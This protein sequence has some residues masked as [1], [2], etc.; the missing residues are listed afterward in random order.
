MVA[1]I[2][3]LI[4]KLAAAWRRADRRSLLTLTAALAATW[5]YFSLDDMDL[6]RSENRV[7][8]VRYA[9]LVQ[10]DKPG[11]QTPKGARLT[12]FADLGAVTPEGA[13]ARSY[14]L[15]QEGF[16]RN[17][18]QIVAA[19]L[20]PAMALNTSAGSIENGR[21]AALQ[22]FLASRGIGMRGAIFAYDGRV[23]NFRIWTGIFIVVAVIFILAGSFLE[24]LAGRIVDRMRRIEKLRGQIE[25][26]GAQQTSV[27]KAALSIEAESLHRLR[28]RIWWLG[29]AAAPFATV[30][31]VLVAVAL[32][33]SVPIAAGNEGFSTIHM[34]PPVFADFPTGYSNV[35]ANTRDFLVLPS[36]FSMFAPYAG[37]V[38]FVVFL[39][40]RRY[41]YAL[42]LLFLGLLYVFYS[43]FAG[44]RDGLVELPVSDIRTETLVSMENRLSIFATAERPLA[45]RDER[46]REA[47]E[48]TLAQ[49]AYRIG[50]QRSTVHH[51]EALG[52][53][54]YWNI[55]AVQWRLAIMQDWLKAN[56]AE[57]S[58]EAEPLA[59]PDVF[60][61]ISS[62]LIIAALALI[63]PALLFL[64]LAILVWFRKRRIELFIAEIAQQSL[65]NKVAQLN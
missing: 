28:K 33:F 34:L 43:L 32:H 15:A 7:P 3:I 11:K 48:Y 38:V 35:S 56:G 17:D 6:W 14:A 23:S 31:I 55:P 21:L 24:M 61:S 60:R 64:S 22:N 13:A 65:G 20:G 16:Y 50:D 37:A 47:Y 9:A 54:Q 27:P 18:P 29:L 36:F 19:H 40:L 2:L 8:V 45:E 63:F 53:P 41:R 5:F 46:S 25:P 12:T 58:A 39:A 52:I 42:A 44:T 49:V 1:A 4:Y 59:S 30:A 10:K 62:Q 26:K 51:L 57:L